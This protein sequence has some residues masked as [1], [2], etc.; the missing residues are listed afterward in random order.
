MYLIPSQI[1]HLKCAAEHDA[2]KLVL[3]C[4]ITTGLLVSYL[5]QYHKIIQKKNSQGLSLW[6][7]FLGA[8][9]MASTVGNIL[10]LQ[11]PSVLCCRSSA[12]TALICFEN[13]FGITQLSLQTLCFMTIMLLF[14]IYYP[15]DEKY[16][17]PSDPSTYSRPW[18]MA[19]GV[20]AFLISYTTLLL[21][22]VLIILWKTADEDGNSEVAVWFAGVLGMLAMMTAI[23]QFLPQIVHTL[24]TKKIGALS[25][26]T[27]AMQSPGS[28]IFAYSLAVQPGANWSSWLPY[29]VSGILQ[30]VL[31]LIC[32]ALSWKEK[33]E[34][35]L[36]DGSQEP[37]LTDAPPRY[38]E[39][40]IES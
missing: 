8:V 27:M 29:L 37:L 9:G 15:S 5:P 23:S 10:L 3:G 13:T 34:T 6:F 4:F 25:I 16:L 31:M 40:P 22:S 12:W 14:Y 18:R 30:G 36:S 24:K 39:V 33:R 17:D 28:L 21:L 7:L 1:I 35:A 38:D 32:I 19:I 20:G 11:Y 2:F 26:P